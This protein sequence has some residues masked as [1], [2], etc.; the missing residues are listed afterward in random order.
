MSKARGRAPLVAFGKGGGK[1]QFPLQFSLGKRS[2]KEK[3]HGKR[4]KK[5]GPKEGLAEEKRKARNPLKKD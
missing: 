3:G 5:N 4:T 1:R 2:G